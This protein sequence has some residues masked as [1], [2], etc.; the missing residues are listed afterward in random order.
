MDNRI[1]KTMEKR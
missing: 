1:W